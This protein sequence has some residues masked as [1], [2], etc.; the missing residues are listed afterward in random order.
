MMRFSGTDETG[1]GPGPFCLQLRLELPIGVVET[2]SAGAPAASLPARVVCE[3]LSII[4][5]RFEPNAAAAAA[6]DASLKLLIARPTSLATETAP[7]VAARE[8]PIP[9][10]RLVPRQHHPLA[11]PRAPPK[12]PDVVTHVVHVIDEHLERRDEHEQGCKG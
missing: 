11:L 4:A 9:H 12:H 10:V 5:P 2:P 1:T 8:G 6:A 3:S 7:D